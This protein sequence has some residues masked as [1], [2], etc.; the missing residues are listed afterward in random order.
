[1]FV[2]VSMFVKM[3]M[4]G[5]LRES[6]KVDRFFERQKSG[7]RGIVFIPAGRFTSVC[8][9]AL[10]LTDFFSGFSSPGSSAS[11]SCLWY[12]RPPP[13]NCVPSEGKPSAKKSTSW[14]MRVW[15]AWHGERGIDKI[16]LEM[17]CKELDRYI[18]RLYR[19]TGKVHTLRTQITMSL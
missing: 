10:S 14:G 12:A 15:Q 13:S 18:A 4:Q 9:V 1:M 3:H 17:T 2:C 11:S 7:R 8:L 6:S 16:T 5:V 19:K